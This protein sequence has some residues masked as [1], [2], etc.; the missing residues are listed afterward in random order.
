MSNHKTTRNVI[1]IVVT[2]ARRFQLTPFTRRPIKRRL[3]ARR[4]INTR[5]IGII[6]AFTSWRTIKTWMKGK[7]GISET[8]TP[9][10]MSPSDADVSTLQGRKSFIHYQ[11]IHYLLHYIESVS[12]YYPCLVNVFY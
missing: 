8:R 3:F 5:R 11:I 10:I 2:Q 6:A 7:P 9:K 4:M 12:R 1:E